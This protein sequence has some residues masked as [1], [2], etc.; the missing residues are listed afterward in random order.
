MLTRR[1]S[2]RFTL[3][4]VLLI[5]ALLVGCDQWKVY[6]PQDLA[7]ARKV[8]V[9]PAAGAPGGFGPHAGR[10][11][12]GLLITAL[13]RTGRFKV[14]GPARLRQRM[15]AFG[16]PS[17]WS[18]DTQGALAAELG[19][20]LLAI[21]EVVDYRPTVDTRRSNYYFGSSTQ[22]ESTFWASVN[23]RLIRPADGAI[24]Y[25]GT[26]TAESKD[27]YGPAMLQATDQAVT[28]L[29]Q[30]LQSNPPPPTPVEGAQP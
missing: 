13:D 17:L 8:V 18:A 7:A 16:D 9:L 27:G 24:V 25:Y 12:T 2:H 23:V 20:D 5:A 29:N 4:A 28:G 1:L 26:G 30:F 15:S 19:A 11:Q 6:E 3:L 14:E 21:A 22:T 10:V